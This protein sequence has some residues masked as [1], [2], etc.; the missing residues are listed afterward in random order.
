MHGESLAVVSPGLVRL[1]DV[2]LVGL[3][4]AGVI[5][6]AEHMVSTAENRT[7]VIF[8]TVMISV[9]DCDL[10]HTSWL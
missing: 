8:V 7:V 1:L 5:L 4:L 6:L 9:T 10:S 2:E 3:V